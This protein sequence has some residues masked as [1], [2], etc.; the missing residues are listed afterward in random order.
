MSVGAPGAD[1]D[2]CYAAEVGVGGF[3]SQSFGV[4][5]GGGKQL[6]GDIGAD[7]VQGDQAGRGCGHERADVPV[8]FG[9]LGVERLHP[10]RDRGEAGGGGVLWVV[11]VFV[12]DGQ[13]R[14]GIDQAH[15]GE[16]VEFAAQ[17]FGGGHDQPAKLVERRCGP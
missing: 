10:A 9:D 4:V 12:V 8:G 11:E 6:A 5:S 14:A 3:A 16:A 7:A 1:G 15:R 17:I 13:V 2:G